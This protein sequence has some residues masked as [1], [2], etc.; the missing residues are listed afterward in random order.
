MKV[1]NKLN[2]LR[3]GYKIINGYMPRH[4]PMFNQS[5]IDL[6]YDMFGLC[7]APEVVIAL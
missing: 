5:A 7:C 1:L 2:K 6:I 3:Y 4:I